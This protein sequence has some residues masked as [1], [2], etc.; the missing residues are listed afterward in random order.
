MDELQ[1]LNEISK[2]IVHMS[3]QRLGRYMQKNQLETFP[4]ILSG[5]D[6]VCV[7]EESTHYLYF[8]AVFWW[9]DPSTS[10]RSAQDDKRG[11][12]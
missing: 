11:K 5:A 3:Q 1:H 7:V 10:L 12:A 9:E 2:K 4:V 8:C 6:K